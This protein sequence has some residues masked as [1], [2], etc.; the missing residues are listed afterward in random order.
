MYVV[1]VMVCIL[2]DSV[3]DHV[4]SWCVLVSAIP[5]GCTW[6]EVSPEDFQWDAWQLAFG[7]VAFEPTDVGCKLSL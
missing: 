6:Q 3:T 2:C 7:L 5:A 4:C 1:S